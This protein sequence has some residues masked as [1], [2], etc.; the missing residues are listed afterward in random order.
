MEV[1]RKQIISQIS[2]QIQNWP[3][4]L[5]NFTTEVSSGLIRVIKCYVI[6]FNNIYKNY[7]NLL[8]IISRLVAI[9]MDPT[10]VSPSIR[11]GLYTFYS[12]Y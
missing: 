11:S 8:F 1:S 12:L 5:E 4:E 9:I 10:P 2:V 7:L 3:I 6:S